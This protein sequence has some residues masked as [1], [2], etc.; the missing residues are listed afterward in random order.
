MYETINVGAIKLACRHYVG[1]KDVT[2]EVVAIRIVDEGQW[3]GLE[4]LDAEAQC[5]ADTVHDS[6][7]QALRQ[8]HF[9]YDIESQ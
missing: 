5:I 7:E 2:H 1:S 9:E 4:R 6:R 8:A 3:Y